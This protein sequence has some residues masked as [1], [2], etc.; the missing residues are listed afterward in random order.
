MKK[1]RQEQKSS[2]A[3][4][5]RIITA[6]TGAPPLNLERMSP[7]TVVQYKDKYFPV[8]LG[9][10]S[11]HNLFRIGIPPQKM[12]NALFT[13]LH[14]DH[15][16]DYGIFLVGGWHSGRRNLTTI[17]PDG[18]EEMYKLYVEMFRKDIDYRAK[19]GT[20]TDGILQN[21]DFITVAGG[22]K[23]ELDGVTISTQFVPHTAYTV[24]YKFEADGKSIVVSGDMTYSDDFVN[25]A[26]GA[27]VIVM[28]ANMA[29]SLANNSKKGSFY[30]NLL[31]SHATIAQVGE[32]ARKA[33]AKSIILT[34][35]TPYSYEAQM[36]QTVAKEY[37]GPIFLASD[38]MAIDVD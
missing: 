20:S 37:D 5:F 12:T 25:F 29:D 21:M 22:E 3:E 38:N 1:V 32:M 16:L 7:C 15:S 6:G 19:L 13:H 30:D 27:D 10:G 36:I 2:V 33:E 8:D 34:H 11:V 17:G 9:Y 4:G 18:T 31:K 14:S 24:A 26:K 28:D 35:L 23:F